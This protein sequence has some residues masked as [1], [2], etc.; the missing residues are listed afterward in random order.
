MASRKGKGTRKSKMTGKIMN[1]PELKESFEIL[2]QKVHE[3]LKEGN[4]MPE[5]VKKFQKLW[6]SIFFRQVSPESAK[7]FLEM[8]MSS[9]N[10]KGTR[11]QKGGAFSALAGAPLDYTTRPGV[12]GTYGSF[13]AYMTS[14]LDNYSKINQIAMDADCG[15]KD[16]TPIVPSSMGSNNP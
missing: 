15:V 3:I 12:D 14:G 4:P 13:P 10:R 9:K 16:I 1:I 2:D 5:T 8:K 6:K 7:A 11:K